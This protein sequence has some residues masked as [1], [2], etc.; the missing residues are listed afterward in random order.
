MEPDLLLRLRLFL[1]LLFLLLEQR[2]V[3]SLLLVSVPTLKLV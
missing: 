2:R 1:L 3:L